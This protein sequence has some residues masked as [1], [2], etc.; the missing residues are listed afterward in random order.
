MKLPHNFT[1]LAFA[2][3]ALI[4]AALWFALAPSSSAQPTPPASQSVTATTSTGALVSPSNFFTGNAAAISTVVGNAGINGN[5][6]VPA[7]KTLTLN[8]VATGTPTS[9][10][11]SLANLTLTLPNS[12][13]F[14]G[15]WS[16]AQGGTGVANTGKTI[17]LGG[18]LAT[19]GAFNL[20]ASLT[21]NTSVTFP[22]TGTLATLAGA[23]TLSNKS[24]TSPSVT[25]VASFAAGTNAAPSIAFTGNTN[26][27]LYLDSADTVGVATAGAGTVLFSTATGLANI[28]GHGTR[29]LV[30]S[31]AASGASLV[32]GQGAS[33]GNATITP[34]GTGVVAIAGTGSKL[35]IAGTTAATSTTTGA[36]QVAGGVGIAGSIFGGS[37]ASFTPTITTSGAIGLSVSPSMTPLA[38]NLYGARVQATVASGAASGGT[39]SAMNASTTNNGTTN[40]A[41]VENFTSAVNQS[42]TSGTLTN[43]MGFKSTL[44]LLNAGNVSSFY[45]FRAADTFASSTGTLANQYA[46]YVDALSRGTVSNYA[47]YSAGA[48]KFQIS[49]TTSA[50]SSTTGALTI[51]NGTAA[52][53]VA[54]GGG[55]INAG[56]TITA[57]G[58]IVGTTTNNNAAAGNEGEELKT[59]VASGSAVSL[60]TATST[61]LASVSLTAGDWDVFVTAIYIPGATT[62]ISQL[63]QGISQTTG[64]LPTTTTGAGDYTV[65]STAAAVPGTNNI[66]QT[67]GP[68]RVSLAGTTTVYAVCRPTF[69]LSTLT[70]YGSIRA[71]RIR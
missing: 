4:A 68:V 3:F 14:S 10:T 54:I 46:F 17:T 6:T 25:G 30:L 19:S 50:S 32:L 36:F 34:T 43:V 65:F 1:R 26:T 33:A 38:A 45:G 12:P 39:V 31:G 28:T 7:G 62:S 48:G 63:S 49:D 20:T 51:G 55:N 13:T 58:G 8:G 15:T 22:T 67:V 35:T 71:R 2:P 52:T 18:N 27:G 23:E 47:F 40:V 56:G 57:G 66:S 9:G 16:G 70:V 44:A 60:T 21:G 24:L 5:V 69:T 53:N 41:D 29:S 37:T 11:L 42:A 64:T 59:T 61:N